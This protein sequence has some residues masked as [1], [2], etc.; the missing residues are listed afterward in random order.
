MA[1]PWS[2]DSF[3]CYQIATKFG[4][5]HKNSTIMAFAA[6]CKCDSIGILI[7][8]RQIT[9]ELESW[10]KIT[11]EMGYWAATGCPDMKAC[12]D[13]MWGGYTLPT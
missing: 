8:V 10:H 6:N 3:V 9:I 13:D 1:K 4:T 12:N 2:C 11:S 5:C 7:K